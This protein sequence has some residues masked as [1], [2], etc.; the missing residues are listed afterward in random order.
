VHL[1]RGYLHGKT[2]RQVQQLLGAGNVWYMANATKEE[3]LRGHD[4]GKKKENPDSYGDMP[5]VRRAGH[6]PRK[7]IDG[8]PV[9]S[10]PIFGGLWTSEE[11][12]TNEGKEE[13]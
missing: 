11:V 12:A 6:R 2:S 9:L 10:G 13:N 3:I 1:S 4:N 8:M 5:P 7:R